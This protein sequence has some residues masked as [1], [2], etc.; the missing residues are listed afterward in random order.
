MVCPKSCTKDGLETQI[1]V[2]H[3]G[4]FLL[5][6]LLLDVIKVSFNK[7]FS[8]RIHNIFLQISQPSRIIVVS[9]MAHLYGKIKKDDINSENSYNEISC[10]C[11]SKLANVL[12]TKELARRLKDTA[13]T[14]NALHPGVVNTDLDRH[15]G[16]MAKI[17]NSWVFDVLRYLFY[18]TAES[19]CQTTLYVA[20]DPDLDKVSGKYFA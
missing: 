13:V 18:K 14:V 17:Y 1:G 20:L 3:F 8:N 11:Q 12:F 6:H 4:H 5:T 9:S 2:N 16:K 15:V 19:G 7:S 10:Y